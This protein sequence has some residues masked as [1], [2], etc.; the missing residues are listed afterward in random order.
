MAEAA[1]EERAPLRCRADRSA[2]ILAIEV[3]RSVSGREGLRSVGFRR[4]PAAQFRRS[5]VRFDQ[6]GRPRA[7]SFSGAGGSSGAIRATKDSPTP[8]RAATIGLSRFAD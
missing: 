1:D 5:A 3:A 4:A 2:D 7:G 6:C 8:L